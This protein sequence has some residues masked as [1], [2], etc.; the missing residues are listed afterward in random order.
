[1]WAEFI[2]VIPISYSSLREGKSA[3]ALD[4]VLLILSLPS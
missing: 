3:D 4:E 1:M 2:F